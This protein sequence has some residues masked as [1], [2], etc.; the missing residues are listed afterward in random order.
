M[1]IKHYIFC[2]CLIMSFPV[3]GINAVTGDIENKNPDEVN[4]VVLKTLTKLGSGYHKETDTKGF[5]FHYTSPV[6]NLYPFDIYIGEYGGGSMIRIE[7]IDKTNTALLDVFTSENT[8][9]KYQNTYQPK[10]LALEYALTFV[11]PAAG[12]LYTNIDSPFSLKFS[13][14]FPILYL[15]IDAGLVWMG[16]T[17][18]FTHAFDPF[19]TGLA[20]TLILLG[21]HRIVHMVFNHISIVAQNRMIGLGYTFQFK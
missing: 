1:K 9:I 16:G 21:T 17:T 5:S 3:F 14:L 11:L 18:F 4:E 19:N 12:N 8:G 20:S 13:W 10:S 7:S 15:G 6:L 2:I